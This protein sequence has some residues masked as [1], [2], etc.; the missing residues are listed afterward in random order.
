MR[1]LG[2]KTFYLATDLVYFT[3]CEHRTTLDMIDLETPM[4]KAADSEEMEFIQNRGY[5][6]EHD[7]MKRLRSGAASF[8]EISAGDLGN[9]IRGLDKAAADTADAIRKGADIIYQAVLCDGPYCGYADFLRRVNKP[10]ALGGFSYEV[11]DTKLSRTAKTSYI[12][13]LCFYSELLARLQGREPEMFWL[14]LG[15]KRKEGFRYADFS[16]YYASIKRRFEDKI[17][18]NDR[19]TY[20]EPCG[21]CE[22]CVWREICKSQ[23]EKEDHLFQVANI[24]KTQVRRLADAG[25]HTLAALARLPRNTKIHKMSPDTFQKLNHQARLQLKK[26][27]TGRDIYE[28]LH[29]DPQGVRGFFRLPEPDD[30]DLFFD[31]EGDPLEP[32]KL[33]YL[34]GLYYKSGRSYTFTPF[35]GHDRAGEKKAFEGF[36]DFVTNHLKKHPNAQ[37]YHYA[38]YEEA[39][40]KRLMCLHGTREAE[41]DSLLRKKK[42]VDLY[43]V[44]REGIRVSEPSYSIKNIEVF[45]MPGERKGQVK[46]AMASVVFYERWRQEKDS[47]LLDQ[48]AK[49]NEDDCRS[50]FL[51]REWL[52]SL[53]PKGIGWFKADEAEAGR[54]PEE[55]LTEAE[56]L[57]IPYR[58]RLIDPLPENRDDWT[59]EHVLDELIFYLLDFHRRE[60]KPGYW[61]LFTRSEM[62][63]DEALEDPECLGA[64]KLDKK[65][66]PFPDKR[67]YL[68]T[69]SFRT[70]N[71]RSPAARAVCASGSP[72]GTRSINSSSMK[73]M[74]PSG[75]DMRKTGRRCPRS[76]AS[77]H[78]A[79]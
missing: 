16:K 20:P 47:R 68:Y 12:I 63:D 11:V 17:N 59:Q 57:L 35:W 74:H 22:F 23:W 9:D 62:S 10:S 71:P 19:N 26:R 51:L 66:P 32:G 36:M 54:E 6:H 8:V 39:A 77:V 30:G 3:Q 48:I 73:K 44:V 55:T 25:I 31:M 15:D 52:L 40:L 14:V 38:N 75:S 58:R 27:E 43:K 13:Q 33:E 37:I 76:S 49:Y 46:N 7:Y 24:S 34:F 5:D 67:S 1:I 78:P 79:P 65:H 2:Q 53:R 60:D 61:A 29:M 42:L 70:R 21:L 41:V 72:P 4:K 69:Y 18:S 56:K 64:L 28:L 50:T 45:Y